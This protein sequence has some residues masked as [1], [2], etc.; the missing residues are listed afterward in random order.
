MDI[1]TSFHINAIIILLYLSIFVVGLNK[2]FTTSNPVAE[3]DIATKKVVYSKALLEFINDIIV[4][5]TASQF[6]A[7]KDGKGI[8]RITEANIKA[9]AMDISKT[10][11][12]AISHKNGIHWD[13]LMFDR[14]YIDQYIINTTIQ[15]VKG[16]VQVELN[17][18]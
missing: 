7:I 10:I 2:Y 5:E 17:R 13:C 11:Y 16:A 9:I 8:D 12:K 3:C 18:V 4:A 15:A 6:K 14:D 1:L